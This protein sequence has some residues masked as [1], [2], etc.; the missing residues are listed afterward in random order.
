MEKER[1]R[2]SRMITDRVRPTLTNATIASAIIALFVGSWFAKASLPDPGVLPE[3]QAGNPPSRIVSMAPGITETLFAL[4]LGQRV[5]GV[6]RFCNFPAEVAK[7]PRV[8]G[9]LDPNLEAILR[10][11]PDLVVVMTEQGDLAEALNKLGVRT[12]SV[13]DDSVKQVLDT[14]TT[15]GTR[16]GVTEQATA[17]VD[18]LQCRMQAIRKCITGR[19]R[20]SVLIVLDRSLGTG[21]IEDAYVA[22][23][24]DYFESLIAMAGG[25]NAYRGPEIPYPVVSIEGIIRMAPDVIIDLAAGWADDGSEQ[26][27]TDW[28]HFPQIAAVRHNRIHALTADYAMVPGPRF[29]LLLEALAERIHA[30]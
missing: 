15:L 18:S 19:R 8:G 2:M 5:V 26:A 3:P 12:L 13:S 30:E 20:P 11:R 24:D 21:T 27:L 25:R 28:R 7:L 9:H 16:C 4:G 14:I 17:L 22:G 29:I 1:S 6:T 10:L 23:R